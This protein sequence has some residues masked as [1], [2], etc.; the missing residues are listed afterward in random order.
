MLILLDFY[1]ISTSKYLYLGIAEK[2]HKTNLDGRQHSKWYLWR[3]VS[4][5]IAQFSTPDTMILGLYLKS[6]RR[7][8]LS[9]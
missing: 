5:F 4:K 3:L 2:I 1:V 8:I 7:T 6:I 9:E